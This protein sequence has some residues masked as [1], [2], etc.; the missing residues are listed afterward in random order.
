MQLD[1]THVVSVPA[2]KPADSGHDEARPGKTPFT[3]PTPTLKRRVK[4]LSKRGLRRLFEYAQQLGVDI[5]PRHFYSEVPDI[6]ELKRRGDWKSPRTMIGVHGVNADEPFEFLESCCTSGLRTHLERNDLFRDACRANGGPGFGPVDAD[7]LFCFIHAVRPQKIV[8]V[9]CG[10]STAVML[11]AAKASTDYRPE[12]VCIEPFPSDFLQ[13]AHRTGEICLVEEK[14]QSVPLELLTDL[15]EEGLLFVDSTHTVKPGSDVN[16]LVFE[17]LPRLDPGS[18]VHF[19]DVYFP[20]DY[21][22]GILDDELFFSNETALLH[23]FM[24]N[25]NKYRIMLSLSMLHYSGPQRLGQSLPNYRPAGND[26]GLKT[27]DGHFPSSLYLRA[28]ADWGSS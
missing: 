24:I 6:K 21:Q 26:C 4:N 12:I 18:W 19:H 2:R 20:Y 15:G 1:S 10:V 25:N 13:A 5:L 3:Q 22:R 14:A 17:V 9:G 7:F 27:A 8:Q 23:A 11:N 28:S 16:R